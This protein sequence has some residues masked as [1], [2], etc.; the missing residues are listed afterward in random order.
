MFFGQVMNLMQTN[1][2]TMRLFLTVV[3]LLSVILVG[4]DE[5]E[6]RPETTLVL[7]KPDAVR[8]AHQRTRIRG[9]GFIPESHRLVDPVTGVYTEQDTPNNALEFPLTYGTAQV[10]RGHV[11]AAISM[12]E[13]KGM[14]VQ[15]LP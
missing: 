5:E 4:A 10:A 2:A 12:F 1:L 9:M 13:A 7:L 11:G 8:P 3:L 15:P 6:C 14:E